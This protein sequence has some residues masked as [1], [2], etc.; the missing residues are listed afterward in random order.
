M[1]KGNQ[2]KKGLPQ[3]LQD[4]RASLDKLVAEPTNV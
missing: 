4:A 1:L 2:L 3:L